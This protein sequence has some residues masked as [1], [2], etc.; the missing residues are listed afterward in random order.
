MAGISAQAFTPPTTPDRE[1]FQV[2]DLPGAASEMITV[3]YMVFSFLIE[4]EIFYASD[5]ND[6]PAETW[7]MLGWSKTG[8]KPGFDQLLG[9]GPACYPTEVALGLS[10]HIHQLPLLI[11]DVDDWV[12]HRSKSHLSVAESFQM[13]QTIGAKATYMTGI[14]HLIEHDGMAAL[15]GMIDGERAAEELGAE[16]RKWVEEHSKQRRELK[17]AKPHI[18]PAR[19]GLRLTIRNGQVVAY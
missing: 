11:L 18:R 5:M 12:I 7:K 19:D 3:P 13:A 2:P 14:T 6:M 10:N 16:G 15:C 8:T 17:Q 1:R 9:I 4:G